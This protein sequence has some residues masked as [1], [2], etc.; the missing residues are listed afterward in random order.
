MW[1]VVVGMHVWGHSDAQNYL[2]HFFSSGEMNYFEWFVI[3]F[4]VTAVC[5]PFAVHHLRF[6]IHMTLMFFFSFAR[7]RVLM[8]LHDFSHVCAWESMNR[9]GKMNNKPET[10]LSSSGHSKT[11]EHTNSQFAWILLLSMVSVKVPKMIAYM[12]R[13]GTYKLNC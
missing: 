12:W 9:D 2:Q 4:R 13:N 11:I 8:C 7:F 3:I 5:F 6:I 10:P 1:N